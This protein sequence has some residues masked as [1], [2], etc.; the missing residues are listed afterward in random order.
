MNIN[1]VI[2]FHILYSHIKLNKSKKCQI[3]RDFTKNAQWGREMYRFSKIV[4]QSKIQHAWSN[5]EHEMVIQGNYISL[6]KLERFDVQFELTAK[7]KL[8]QIGS[9]VSW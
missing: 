3:F 7:N 9:A 4:M 8:N 5:H 6:Q 2:A 1:D